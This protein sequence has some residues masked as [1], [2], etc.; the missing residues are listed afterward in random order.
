MMR[1]TAIERGEKLLM[2]FKKVVE[3]SEFMSV[4]VFLFVCFLDGQSDLKSS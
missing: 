2:A 3:E 4:F 1:T